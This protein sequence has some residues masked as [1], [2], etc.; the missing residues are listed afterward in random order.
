[1]KNGFFNPVNTAIFAIILIAA[2]YLV[3]KLIARMKIPIDRHFALAILPFILFAT[4]FRALR[5]YSFSLAQQAS[6]QAGAGSQ[7]GSDIL[8]QFSQI[9]QVASQHIFALIPLPQFSSFYASVLTIFPTPGSYIITFL[10]AFAVFLI[11]VLIMR[12]SK[13][14][15]QYWK[16]MA[17]PP[18]ILTIINLVLL[19]YTDLQ[20]PLIIL[21]G[22]AIATGLAYLLVRLL[23]KRFKHLSGLLD[24]KNQAIMAVHFLDA[25][26]TYFAIQ[27]LGY[28]EQHFLPRFLFDSIGPWVFFI[29]K[30]LVILPVLYYLDKDSVSNRDFT[31]FLKIAIFILGA[32]PGLRSL[33][34]LA[35]GGG[36]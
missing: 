20:A 11:S 23:S 27:Y 8:F 21:I 4:S 7:F 14:K 25:S 10:F 15:I 34:R 19:P 35:V 16:L 12:L 5:D 1:M 26:A 30:P 33:I 17:V 28:G 32:G 22:M 18:S 24:W 31:N 2:V 6:M 3:Y 13:N 9:Q 36:I 29:V